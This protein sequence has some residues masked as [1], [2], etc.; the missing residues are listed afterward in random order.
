MNRLLSKFYTMDIMKMYHLFIALFL[1]SSLKFSFP[2]FTLPVII[3]AFINIP[4]NNDQLEKWSI[5]LYTT[6]F[7]AFWYSDYYL[8]PNHLT[9]LGIFTLYMT[10]R[11]WFKDQ[12]WNFPLYLL[13]LVILVASLQKLTSPY[14]LKGNLIGE[15]L[16][17]GVS[18]PQL[19][20][21]VDVNFYNHVIS[22]SDDFY[23]AKYNHTSKA[24]ELTDQSVIVYKAISWLVITSEVLL[25]IALIFCKP[26]KKYYA[27]L[28]FLIGTAFFRSEYGFFCI[29]LLIGCFDTRIQNKK[30][31]QL[32]KALFLI[33]SLIYCYI[34]QAY[35]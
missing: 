19:G 31:Q 5:T 33:F 11:V 18:F 27:L 17:S 2:L 10:Y 34:I 32:L 25:S 16:L 23:E 8:I 30:V 21:L 29:L 20:H 12:Q 4:I 9:L 13:S 26:V 1:I 7:S 28:L 3:I 14:F 15:L 24:L 6:V 35:L 22:F